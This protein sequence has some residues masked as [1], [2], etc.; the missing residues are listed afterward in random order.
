MLFLW[1]LGPK[2]Y[3]LLISLK[4]LGTFFYMQQLSKDID[5][6]KSVTQANVIVS[7]VNDIYL[8]SEKRQHFRLRQVLRDHLDQWFS[9]RCPWSPG[10]SLSRFRGTFRSIC[11]IRKPLRWLPFPPVDFCTVGAKVTM[12]KTV[13]A[14]ACIKQWHQTVLTLVAFLPITH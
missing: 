6:W 8:R 10:D 5:S 12:G 11:K 9:K 13:G 4:R 3:F 7:L 2:F 14:L 1:D